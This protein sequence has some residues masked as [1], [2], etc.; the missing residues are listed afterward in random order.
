MEK[1][2]T[3][4]DTLIGKKILALHINDTKDLIVFDV[5]GGRIGAAAQGDCCSR[6]YFQHLS[7]LEA[8][9]G[10]TVNEITEHESVTTEGSEKTHG[11]DCEQKYGWTFT[12]NRGRADLDMRND[13]N[14]YYGGNVSI[15][16]Y[17]QVRHSAPIPIAED[18]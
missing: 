17:K 4:F 8:L 16:A 5:E 14:G 12:T 6:S 7:G 18:F 1:I 10:C 9:I 15:F 2:K 13:S 11:S 3:Q